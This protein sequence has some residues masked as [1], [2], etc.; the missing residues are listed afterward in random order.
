MKNNKVMRSQIYKIKMVYPPLGR[1]QTE[2][3]SVPIAAPVELFQGLVTGGMTPAV[4]LQRLMTGDMI[5]AVLLQRL[6]TG[7]M[8]PAVLFQVLVTGDTRWSVF[9]FFF[10]NQ[11]TNGRILRAGH[12]VI[13]C[14]SSCVEWAISAWLVWENEQIIGLK[15]VMRIKSA[16]IWSLLYLCTFR[17]QIDLFLV[18]TSSAH[19]RAKM[20]TANTKWQMLLSSGNSSDFHS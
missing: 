5:P 7:D 19:S 1:S 20:S 8:K 16:W 14:I 9:S 13:C 12:P 11:R 15:F 17:A 3:R 2:D 4:L 6:M 18:A 10:L